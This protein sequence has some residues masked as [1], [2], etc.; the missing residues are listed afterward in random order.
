MNDK[1]GVLKILLYMQNEFV[2]ETT[3]E[4]ENGT[5]LLTIIQNVV[6]TKEER[7]KYEIS[8]RF[9]YNWEP[10]INPCTQILT[11][12]KTNF[13]KQIYYEQYVNVH[14]PKLYLNISN[15]P[16]SCCVIL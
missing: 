7:V 4:F 15:S 16:S 1:K 3:Q 14:L 11:D 8:N 6:P 2:R 12:G 5:T 13:Y 10:N 9:Y